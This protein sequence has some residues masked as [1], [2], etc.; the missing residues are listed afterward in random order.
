MIHLIHISKTYRTGPE[1]FY[2]LNDVSLDVEQGE[3]IAV[4]GPSGAG[5]ST[6]LFLIGGM[7][8]PDQGEV[9]VYG[10]NIFRLSEKE[11][12]KYRSEII[13]F[14]FQQFHLIPYLT[15]EDNISLACST[16]ND[17]IRLSDM[18]KKCALVEKANQYP[19]EL[20]VGEKQRVAFIRAMISNPKIILAD[21]PTGNLDPDNTNVLIQLLKDFS[22]NGGTVLLVT[23]D[24]QLAGVAQRTVFIRNG[25]LAA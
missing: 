24:P 21:E 10:Q 14:V 9:M 20:S 4:C 7:V 12:N 6:M 25:R 19:S 17:R 2:A 3:F 11:K 5:K 22:A 16:P 15:V 1:I 13:G 23:H 8:R 18:L